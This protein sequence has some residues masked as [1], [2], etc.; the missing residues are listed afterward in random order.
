MIIENLNKEEG[1]DNQE[2]SKGVTQEDKDKEN[3]Q[4]RREGKW[5]TEG[6]PKEDG[7]IKVARST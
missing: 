4:I 7:P 3:S 2:D 1:E 6:F 5:T